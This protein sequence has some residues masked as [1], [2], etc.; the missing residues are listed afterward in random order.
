MG[1]RG[2]I[3]LAWNPGVV[4]LEWTL[5]V[6]GFLFAFG[7]ALARAR[8]SNELRLVAEQRARAAEQVLA[9]RERD[10]TQTRLQLEFLSRFVREFPHLTRD[11]HTSSRPRDVARLVL[12]V[13]AHAFEPRFAV[14][15]LRRQRLENETVHHYEVAATTPEAPVQLGEEIPKLRTLLGLAIQGQTLVGLRDL[16]PQGQG[17]AV[18]DPEFDIVAPLV[19]GEQI[20]GA[21]ALC[22][23]ARATDE[24]KA[25]LR[26]IA[27][28]GAQALH[29]SAAFQQMKTTANVDGLTRIFNKRHLTQALAEGIVDA[30]R[31]HVPLSVFLFD[32]DNFK[33]YNDRNGHVA[34]DQLLREMARLVQEH[35]RQEDVFGRFGGEEFLVILRDTPL[36]AALVVA[37]K[38]RGLIASHPFSCGEAQPL[39]HL[40]VSGGVAEYPNDARDSS[41]LLKAADDAL[42]AAKHGGRDRVLGVERRFLGEA[43]LEPGTNQY[44]EIDG[45]WT[46]PEPGGPAQAARPSSASETQ[47]IT[48][49]QWRT[50]PGG[51][52]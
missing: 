39:G 14:V 27:Q 17:P 13:V 21:I 26:L 8:R 2:G 4:I 18:A 49:V 33:H 12:N 6:L 36:S 38:L 45:L 11:L 30:E 34:G 15:L 31:R 22:H 9:V 1:S 7:A 41:R 23:P 42:Y 48:R 5:L 10:N 29:G 52:P 35:V 25:V 28:A 37:E 19:F 40:S 47:Q 24:E 50:V 16:P 32:V 3:Q 46:S 44:G 51:R 20:L 43:A